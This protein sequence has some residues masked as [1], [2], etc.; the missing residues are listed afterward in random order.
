MR[1]AINVCGPDELNVLQ[2]IFDS[3]WIQLKQDPAFHLTDQ[4]MLREQI[5]RKVVECI[6]DDILDIDGIRQ[7]VL[8]SFI[9][10]A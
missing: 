1:T 2:Q 5:S 7:S 6:G 4:E 9:N 8:A 3:V 10:S